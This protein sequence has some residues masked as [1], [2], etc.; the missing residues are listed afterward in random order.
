MNLKL[1]FLVAL[2]G[3]AALASF[4]MPWVSG[5]LGDNTVNNFDHSM[6]RMFVT[7][8]GM[9]TVDLSN[10]I[11]VYVPL[12]DEN[13]GTPSTVAISLCQST[14]PSIYSECVDISETTHELESGATTVSFDY[15]DKFNADNFYFLV[16]NL[17]VYYPG[18]DTTY[19]WPGAGCLDCPWMSEPS[20]TYVSTH[21]YVPDDPVF[22]STHDQTLR[23]SFYADFHEFPSTI[24][25]KTYDIVSDVDATD[26][27]LALS[28]DSPFDPQQDRVGEHPR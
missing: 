5:A 6:Y 21:A 22:Y 7:D 13:A 16:F 28:A 14:S 23:W 12:L 4:E 18:P 9:V 17:S 10:V 25:W 11:G 3:I 20:L 15:G 24:N 1:F 19:S 2:V 27:S 8:D 26:D